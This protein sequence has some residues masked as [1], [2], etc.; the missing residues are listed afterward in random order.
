MISLDKR[1][2]THFLLVVQVAR[3]DGL[4]KCFI[5]NKCSNR[6]HVYSD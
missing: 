3:F 1:W 4:N 6:Y 2:T 5:P